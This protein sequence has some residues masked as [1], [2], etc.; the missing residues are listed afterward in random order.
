M[1]PLNREVQRLEQLT[2]RQADPFLRG[3][4]LNQ[5]REIRVLQVARARQENEKLAVESQNM[6]DFLSQAMDKQK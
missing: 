6:L 3:L 2:S 4:L 5:I 1:D